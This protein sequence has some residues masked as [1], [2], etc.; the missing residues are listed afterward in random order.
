[1]AM[2]SG[3]RWV[4]A[5]LFLCAALLFPAPARAHEESDSALLKGVRVDE[6]L[7]ARVPGELLFRTAAGKTVRLSDALGGG[8][9]ILTLNYYR[10]PMLCPLTLRNLA[11]AVSGLRGPSLA[12]DF[13]IVSVSIDPTETQETAGLRAREAYGALSGTTASPAD[14]WP[15][16]YGDADAVRSLTD[17][18]GFRY[19]KV[20]AEFAHPS[21]FVVL[22]P[23]GT[24]SRYLYGIAPSP[25]DLR[26]ALLEATGGRIGK[27]AVFGRALLLCFH[28]DPAGKKYVLYAANIMKAGGGLTLLAVGFALLAL[29]RRERR[30]A[31]T[32]V[33]RP[34]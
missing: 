26:L 1:M 28:Y 25:R 24:I 4:P 32:A 18:L 22:T 33:G 6:R 20:G 29:W 2:R 30:K 5:I 34:A 9:A 8:P 16:L 23:E 31:G 15:F 27:N 19:R 21:V 14:R 3:F 13:R 17:A 7:G 12:K 11:G 10:C